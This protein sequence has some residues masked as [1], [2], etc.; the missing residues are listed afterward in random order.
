MSE[1]I[2]RK[3]PILLSRYVALGFGCPRM[4]IFVDGESEKYRKKTCYYLL[5]LVQPP[6]APTAHF[7]C[8]GA[9][10]LRQYNTLSPWLST[11]ITGTQY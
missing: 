6:I 9:R 8:G 3:P 10:D 11:G 5:Y 4:S 2:E 7:I 1:R